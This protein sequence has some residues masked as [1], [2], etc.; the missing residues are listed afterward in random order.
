MPA[1]TA[2][3]PGTFCW[4]ELAAKDIQAAIKFYR[5]LFGWDLIEHP[6]G[7]GMTYYVFTKGGHQVGAAFQLDETMMPGVPPHWGTYLSVTDADAAATQTKAL[8]GQVLM[9][10]HEVKVEGREHGRMY[11]LKDS[12]GAVFGVWQARQHAG[13]GLMNEP[14][15]LAWTQLNATDTDGAKK[16]YTQLCGWK[17]QDDPNP[18]GGVYTTWLKADGPAGGM[19][20]MPKGA[21]I[22]S[23]WLCYF[24]TENVDRS[25]AAAMK[26][27]AQGHVPPT[28]IPG[29]GRFSVLADP[30]GAFFALVTFEAAR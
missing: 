19:M 20:E 26:A 9:G 22:P 11:M 18:M 3:L 29:M 1:T 24:A 5:A 25:H 21:P 2:H 10:P 28:D 12:V 14:G 30:Q 8:G 16:F 6:M 4:P 23:H 13:V 17:V 15:S 7:P 27:G